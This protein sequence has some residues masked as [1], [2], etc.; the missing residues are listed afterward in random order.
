MNKGF[1]KTVLYYL[2]GL[3]LAGISYLTVGHDYIHAP[4]LHHIIILLTFI[5][6]FLWLIVATTL[7]F[8]GKRTENLRG[9]IFTNLFAG[10]GFTLFMVYIIHDASDN[11]FEGRAKK[12]TI[13]ESGDTIT[14]YHDGSPV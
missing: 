4:G 9:I 3:G 14:M 12:V 2:A 13:E 11:D 10:L 5:F 1:L 8:T 7:Y 6:G